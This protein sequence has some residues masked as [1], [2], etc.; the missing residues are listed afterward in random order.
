MRDIVYVIITAGGSGTRMGAE[1]PKQF[2]NLCGKPVLRRTLDIFRS[3]PEQVRFILTLPQ[4]QIPWWEEYCSRSNYFL[5]THVVV[6]GGITRFHSVKNAVDYIEPGQ[7][8][9]VH[10]GVRPFVS[11]ELVWRMIGLCRDGAT[12]VVPSVPCV[13]T[14]RILRQEEEHLTFGASVDRT[15][16]YAVQTP[17]VFHSEALVHAYTQP[18]R[19]EFTDDASVVHAAGYDIRYIRGS[20]ANIKLTAPDDMILAEALVRVLD[21]K[22]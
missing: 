20:R 16:I 21:R 18:F 17:Q 12:G 13:D 8:A 22:Q 2:M 10:D 15:G 1:M 9:I 4:A 19:Q 7:I 5:G 6:P 3:L 14:L 11:S